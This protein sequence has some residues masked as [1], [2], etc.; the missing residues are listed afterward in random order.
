MRN[1]SITELRVKL[2]ELGVYPGFYSLDGTLLPDRIVL[3]RNYSK[4]EVFYFTERGARDNEMIFF[5]ESDACEYIYWH[6]VEQKQ[7]EKNK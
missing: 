3:Y 7:I 4:W 6:F 2:N 5:S 1:M